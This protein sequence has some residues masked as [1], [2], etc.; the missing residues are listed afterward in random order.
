V[1]TTVATT[2]TGSVAPGAAAHDAERREQSLERGETSGGE[3][4]L[5]R[6]F[7]R[8]TD[9][10][11]LVRKVLRTI[12]TEARSAGLDPLEHHGLIHLFGAP[13]HVLQMK[14]LVGRLDS[15]QRSRRRTKAPAVRGGATEPEAQRPMGRWKKTACAQTDG[16]CPF[17][18]EAAVATGTVSILNSASPSPKKA[19][20]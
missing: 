18:R 15:A 8:I 19:L 9:T 12:D 3:E 11:Y 17:D 16:D 13:D 20:A 10:R 1:T 14:D 2:G 5:H 7:S 6:Y 4:E